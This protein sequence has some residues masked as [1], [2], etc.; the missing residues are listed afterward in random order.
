VRPIFGLS[1]L[2][3]TT[4]VLTTELARAQEPPVVVAEDA[5]APGDADPGP[6]LPNGEPAP[7]PDLVNDSGGIHCSTVPTAASPL[8]LV[9]LLAIAATKKR[10]EGRSPP[11]RCADRR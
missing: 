2:I 6:R 1:V 5:A 4:S 11:A 9:V 10:R 3:A 7:Q 8:P